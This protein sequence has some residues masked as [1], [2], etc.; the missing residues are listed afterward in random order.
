MAQGKIKIETELV[1]DKFDKQIM[2]LDKKIKKKEDKK[3][4]IEAKLSIQES[5]LENLRKQSDELGKVYQ[6][7]QKL[8]DKLTSGKG[9]P[10][11][12]TTF[13]NL[14]NEYGTLE[15]IGNN[16]DKIVD[17]QDILEAKVVKT[18][19]QYNSINEEISDY[20]TKIEGIKLQKHQSEID[21][22]KQSFKSV[23][24]SI[25]DAV[26]QAGKLVLGI[27]AIRGAYMMLRR[28][29]SDLASYDEQY[30]ANLEY[31]RFVLTQAVAPVLRGIVQLAMQLLQLINMIVNALFGVNLFSKGSAENFQ[32]MKNKAGGVGKAVKEIKKQLLGFD[33]VNIL[34]DQSDTGTSAGAGG[35]GMPS[36]DLSALEGDYPPWMKWLIDNKELVIGA[37]TGI[38][39]ALVLLKFGV[40]GLMSLGIGLII[41]GIISLIQ[42]IIKF[43]KDPSWNNFANILRDI[44]IVLAGI[45]IAML[46]VNAAN[47]I[48]WLV[49][50]IAT[51]ILVAAEVIKNWDKIKEVLGKVGD[52]I[53]THIIKPVSDFFRGLWD[54][55]Y[56]GAVNAWENVKKAFSNIGTFFSN[57]IKN[58]IAKFKD[59]GTKVGNTVSDAFKKI[60]N[61]VLNAIEKILNSPIR[62]INSLIDTING[63]PGINLSRLNTFNFPRLATGGIINMPNKGSLIGGAIAGESGREGIVPLTD[64][65]A[66][67]ELGREIG[68]NVLVNL[69]NITQMNGRVIS[70]ELKQVQSTQDFAYNM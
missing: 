17:K 58:I 15:Q 69:T 53:N 56:N 67:A 50:L 64:Q 18:K 35:V 6:K 23:E 11:D 34:S 2:D 1:T 61:S 26:K 65:Q 13:E 14:Q 31:I 39:T 60:I 40:S 28:A 46:A 47:P 41:A 44:A 43:I 29:S 42:D 66:M 38:A 59:I 32:K 9:M 5:D 51:I 54:K 10:Q 22:V 37:I 8:Q 33:E 55:I 3:V 4:E 25:Q 49:L 45:A 57:V 19:N 30:A 12:Y 36:M 7:M 68:K 63:V 20:K 70:R 21:K 16:L 27:F 62:S 48:A 52:W 24:S